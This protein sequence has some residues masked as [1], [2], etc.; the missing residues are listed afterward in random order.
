MRVSNRAGFIFGLI[1]LIS[2]IV[3]MVN[4]F[5]YDETTRLFPLPISVSAVALMVL[6]LIG[7]VF[8]KV[9][10]KFRS[11]VFGSRQVK[12]EG[13][14]KES[15]KE[16]SKRVQL[17]KELVVSCWLILFVV[18]ILLLGYLIAIPVC[19]LLFAKFYARFSWLR[20][21]ALAAAGIGFVYLAFYLPLG[22][23]LFKGVFFGGIL[24]T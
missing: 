16:T 7:D 11:D 22:V 17:K 21:T 24:P 1:L 18:L 15:T 2:L 5:S 3:I 20:A 14:I 10:S 13:S 12:P 9:A 4:S 8:P 6:S 19:L 23:E